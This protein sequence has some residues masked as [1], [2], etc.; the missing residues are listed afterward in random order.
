[1]GLSLQLTSLSIEEGK[2][3]G[4]GDGNRWA[5]NDGRIFGNTKQT[6]E[7]GREGRMARGTG[8]HDFEIFK[9]KVNRGNVCKRCPHHSCSTFVLNETSGPSL[10]LAA[11]SL[12]S[13]SLFPRPL[14][15]CRSQSQSQLQL[16]SHRHPLPRLKH[17]S[18][19]TFSAH[20]HTCTECSK[21]CCCHWQLSGLH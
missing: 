11:P 18:E 14:S 4:R 1:M 3:Q 15:L 8:R 5:G 19:G 17:E 21:V 9:T 20:T 13:F 6:R 16:Q 10:P 12:T 7:G 2:S